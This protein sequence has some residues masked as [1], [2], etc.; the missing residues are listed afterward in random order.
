[1]STC[2]FGMSA[3]FYMSAR[4]VPLDHQLVQLGSAFTFS[5]A[6]DDN[7]N[8]KNDDTHA[9]IHTCINTHTH[10]YIYIQPASQTDGQKRAPLCVRVCVYV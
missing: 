9:H 10:I 6:A 1:M 5:D 7:D 8:E 4:G 2:V 3:F